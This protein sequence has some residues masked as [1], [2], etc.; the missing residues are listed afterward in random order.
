MHTV[1]HDLY[2]SLIGKTYDP[3]T[4]PVTCERI[5]GYAKVVGDRSPLRSDVQ[6]ARAAGFRDVVAPPTLGFTL[7]LLAA[8]SDI[9]LADLGFTVNDTLHGEQAFVYGA[10]ICAGD[11]LTGQQTILDV[12]EKKNGTLLFLVTGFRLHN[13]DSTQV[14]DMT[15][16]SIVPLQGE[17][18]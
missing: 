15:Q 18:H 13:Q 10:P 2:R 12:R 3:F 7:T 9:A 1:S 4:V 6:A 8:Q 16:T 5:V 11:F 17:S 14:L